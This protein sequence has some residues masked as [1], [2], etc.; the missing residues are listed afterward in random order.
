MATEQDVLGALPTQ[1]PPTPPEIHTFTLDRQAANPDQVPEGFTLARE[2]DATYLNDALDAVRAA[3]NAQLDA[4]DEAVLATDPVV[5]HFRGV[6]RPAL[7]TVLAEL[8][9]REKAHLADARRARLTKEG[10]E[11]E[12]RQ[13]SAARA[14][15]LDAAVAPLLERLDE[16]EADASDE[17]AA[18]NGLAVDAHHDDVALKLA[19]TLS[20]V[21]VAH[22]LPLIARFI[23]D[24][25]NE[26]GLA[27]AALPFLRSLFD[28]EGTAWTRH[29]DLLRAT[30]ACEAIIQASSARAAKPAAAK[31]EAVKRVR[32][33]LQE[34]VVAVKE[35]DRHARTAL[36][37]AVD[38]DGRLVLFPDDPAPAPR[39]RENLKDLP[40]GRPFR[41]ITRSRS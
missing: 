19:A 40:P 3:V 29:V 25:V 18:A 41:R 20:H 10:R 13:L 39:P 4:A 33:Q 38:G 34:M 24:A 6:V 2:A 7:V 15:R 16:L 32:W 12:D 9:A 8:D 11:E 27:Y 30:R 1:A 37:N 31:V 36:L 17:L 14:A 26:P 5:A 35:P 23:K 28:R 21:T 22:G